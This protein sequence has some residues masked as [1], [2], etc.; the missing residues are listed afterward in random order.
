MQLQGDRREQR[1]QT[2]WTLQA[3][4]CRETSSPHIPPHCFLLDGHCNAPIGEG[5]SLQNN[6]TIPLM[7]VLPTGGDGTEYSAGI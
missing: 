4:S 2:T 1:E 3:A 5:T 6:Q 7:C